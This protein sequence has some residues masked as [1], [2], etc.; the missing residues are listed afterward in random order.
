MRGGAGWRF[1]RG[2]PGRQLMSALKFAALVFMSNF[3]AA[4]AGVQMQR[5]LP[6]KFGIPWTGD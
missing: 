3:L 2:A 6:D 1:L 5:V 4:L